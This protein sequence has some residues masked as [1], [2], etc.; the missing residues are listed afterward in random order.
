MAKIIV[1][2]IRLIYSG[3]KYFSNGIGRGDD[4]KEIEVIRIECPDSDFLKVWEDLKDRGLI[5][6]EKKKQ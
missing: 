4:Y 5:P 2:D 3:H 1:R 6:M